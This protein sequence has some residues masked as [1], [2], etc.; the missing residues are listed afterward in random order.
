MFLQ[1]NMKNEYV[2]KALDM[3]KI[4]EDNLPA[5]FCLRVFGNNPDDMTVIKFKL[6]SG[7]ITLNSTN[8]ENFIEGLIDGIQVLLFILLYSLHTIGSTLPYFISEDPPETPYNDENNTH[9][10]VGDTFHSQVLL[11]QDD[12]ILFLL[13]DHNSDICEKVSN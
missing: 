10:I 5:L 9:H 3:F 1:G 4:N 6:N 12:D 11:N 13:Y 2:K 8:I 7:M